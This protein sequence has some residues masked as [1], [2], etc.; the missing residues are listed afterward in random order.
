MQLRRV[1][2]SNIGSEGM[3][4]TRFSMI[5]MIGFSCPEM[6]QER[7]FKLSCSSVAV[8]PICVSGSVSLWSCGS[9]S[10]IGS[11]FVLVIMRKRS[12]SAYCSVIVKRGRV[13]MF[14]RSCAAP[15]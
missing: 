10:L 6:W 1:R 3:I 13:S 12:I 8:K 9:R 4:S 5:S 15:E 7:F 2:S 11:G 14:E